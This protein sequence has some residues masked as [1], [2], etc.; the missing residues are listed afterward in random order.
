MAAESG[1]YEK[2]HGNLLYPFTNNHSVTHY[3]LPLLGRSPLYQFMLNPPRFLPQPLKF[4][5][6]GVTIP[7]VSTEQPTS[8]DQ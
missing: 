1:R 7:R 2:V 4:K 6:K 5:F 8:S 3:L